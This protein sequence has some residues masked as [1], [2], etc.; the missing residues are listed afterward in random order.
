MERTE[1]HE[2]SAAYA[3]DALGPDELA[4]F[5]AHLAHCTECR[6]HVAAFQETVAELA[7]D[8]EAPAPSPALRNR[9]LADARREQPKVVAMPRR[10]W[11]FPVAAA[12]AFAAGCV[13]LGLAFWA[14]D[15]ANQ[16]DEERTAVH[17][18]DEIIV[19]LT[20]P[21][22]D[23]IPLEGADGILV[24]DDESSE[25]WMLVNGLD[26]APDGKTYEAWVI[27]DGEAV[28]AGLFTGGDSRT[29]V[30]LTVP[31]SEGAIVAVTVEEAG[32]VQ[33]PTQDPIFASE[34]AA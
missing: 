19:A 5:E 22:A 25:G 28:P 4:E 9:V 15:L 8:V 33:Q 6:E 10:R 29:V 30:P 11:A 24:V 12:A 2:L 32:G 17:L 26:Q 18:A 23:R 1:I 3:L 13:A 16:L 21:N 34:Q 14:S 31:V 7:Y 20:D 27:E